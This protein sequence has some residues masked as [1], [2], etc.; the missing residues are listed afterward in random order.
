MQHNQH[1]INYKQWIDQSGHFLHISGKNHIALN[2]I[3]N[4]PISLRG[5]RQD[6]DDDQW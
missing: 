3:I 1:A 5:K 4:D 2:S 6:D